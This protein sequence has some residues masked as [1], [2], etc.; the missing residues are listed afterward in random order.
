MR[1]LLP[2]L[3]ATALG[4]ALLAAPTTV[5][6]APAAAVSQRLTNLDHLDFLGTRVAPPD[7]PGHTTYRLAQEP[8]IGT[9]WTYADRRDDGS[10]ERVGGGAYDPA[11]DTWGQGAFNADD[12][13]RAAVVYLRDWQQH[14][15]ASSR[16]AAYD[17]LRGVAY[18]Q[19]V[20]GPDAGNVVLWMQPDGTLNPSAEPVEQPDPSDSE[21][22]YWLAR[23][24]WALG[25]GYA[26]F[27]QPTRRSPGSSSNG[28]TW[29]SARWTVRCSTGTASTCRSMASGCRPG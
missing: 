18:H 23:T 13:T 25:E 5:S 20:T 16:D 7:Q 9:L 10:Y 22:S 21:E 6:S 24:I 28:W 17:L 14:D 15:R 1:R 4:A 27:R 29:R 11:T 2:V 19:T 12:V 3:A 26:A 8:E